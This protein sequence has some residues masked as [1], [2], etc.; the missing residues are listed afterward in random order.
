MS[1]YAP[2]L[3]TS[4]APHYVYELAPLISAPRTLV[5]LHTYCPATEPT[6]IIGVQ[7]SGHFVPTSG[8]RVPVDAWIDILNLLVEQFSNGPSTAS[9]SPPW[10]SQCNGSCISKSPN[11]RFQNSMVH[12]IKWI[13]FIV[14]FN[15]MA[16]DKFPVSWAQRLSYIIQHI[17]G[18]LKV[19]VEA[20]TNDYQGYVLTHKQL[21][22]GLKY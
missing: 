15:Y 21:K 16:H 19:S 14:K 10:K 3:V 9:V 1:H 12:P 7:T 4:D 6:A 18:E 20:F 17:S 5:D 11:L 13:D 22:Y 2:G 8:H